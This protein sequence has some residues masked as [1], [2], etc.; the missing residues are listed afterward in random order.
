[1]YFGSKY[2]GFGA[3]DQGIAIKKRSYVNVLRGKM[4]E[5]NPFTDTIIY[6]TNAYADRW[7]IGEDQTYIDLS[8]ANLPLDILQRPYD[9]ASFELP[10]GFALGTLFNVYTNDATVG[11]FSP[12]QVLCAPIILRYYGSSS[13]DREAANNIKVFIFPNTILPII[14]YLPV[15]IG[16]E[17]GNDVILRCYM[18]LLA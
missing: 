13:S 8:S 4:V 6:A 1:M 15:K 16:S 12:Q 14:G 18:L 9:D 17:N 10:D 2:I 3:S 11:P 7:N 5:G